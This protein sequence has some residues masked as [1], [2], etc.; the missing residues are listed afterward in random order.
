MDEHYLNILIEK[1]WEG[2]LSDKECAKLLDYLENSDG[3]SGDIL[4]NEHFG[5]LPQETK[6]AP[7][8][9]SVERREELLKCIE[10]K[11]GIDSQRASTPLTR[12]KWI[13]RAAGVAALVAVF[14]V[15]YY[16]LKKWHHPGEM[17]TGSVQVASV[18]LF[19]TIYNKEKVTKRI[20]LSD[21]SEVLLYPDSKI[22]FKPAMDMHIFLTGKAYFKIKHDKG[23]L[24]TV[25][26]GEIMTTDIGTEFEIDAKRKNR[27][28]IRLLKGKVKVGTVPDSKLQMQEQ[29]LQ[30]GEQ[31][32]IQV[33]DK[34]L[35]YEKLSLSGRTHK[36]VAPMAFNKTPLKEVFRKIS[37]RYNTVIGF[38]TEDVA[39]LT[40]TGNV[41]SGDS[42]FNILNIICSINN[43]TLS[44]DK[45]GFV[46]SKD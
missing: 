42:L 46:I 41:E 38:N 11:M 30:Q 34:K 37:E 16:I 28:S 39:N 12:I 20:T 33:G 22:W 5:T 35:A 17:M 14:F 31:L 18:Q 10:S 25:T 23:R 21:K 45:S 9:L 7:G 13:R 19:D 44:K 32:N 3:A 1:L 27:P 24:F 43:L 4:A 36:S 2:S 8:Q 6:D 29:Y 15:S 40:F 26:T